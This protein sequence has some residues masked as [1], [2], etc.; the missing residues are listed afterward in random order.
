[1]SALERYD[2]IMLD[3]ENGVFGSK[4]LSTYEILKRAG[5]PLLL[6]EMTDEE[7]KVLCSRIQAKIYNKS[8]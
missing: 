7:L 1:M 8:V 2:K 3:Y 5:E 6:N 4:D